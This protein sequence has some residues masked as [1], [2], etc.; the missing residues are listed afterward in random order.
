[1]YR[2]K[3]VLP[4]SVLLRCIDNKMES[5]KGSNNDLLGHVTAYVNTGRIKRGL[6]YLPVKATW[7][8]LTTYSQIVF[9]L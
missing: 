6:K 5:G 3:T 2:E 4:A 1:M 9:V 7:K 8:P